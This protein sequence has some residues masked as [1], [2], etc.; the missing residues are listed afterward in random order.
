MLVAHRVGQATQ[1]KQSAVPKG[2]D[3]KKGLTDRN[4]CSFR[5]VV[6]VSTFWI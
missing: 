5:I 4:L 3:V 2:I 1:G 6:V